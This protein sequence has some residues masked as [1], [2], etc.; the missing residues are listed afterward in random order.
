MT[1]VGNIAT[2]FPDSR[3]DRPDKDLAAVRAYHTQQRDAESPAAAR[4]VWEESYDSVEVGRRPHSEGL[5][6]KPA[7]MLALLSASLCTVT[8]GQAGSKAAPVSPPEIG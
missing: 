8:Q 5:M 1:Y 7:L 3:T 6:P 4:A 2:W